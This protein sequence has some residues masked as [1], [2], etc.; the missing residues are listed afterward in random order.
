LAEQEVN[1]NNS[2]RRQD[3]LACLIINYILI[4]MQHNNWIAT[5]ATSKVKLTSLPPKNSN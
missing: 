2:S 4:S 3:G 5:P 1:E